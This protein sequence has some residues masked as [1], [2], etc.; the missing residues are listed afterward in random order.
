M[1]AS[2]SSA[3]QRNYF[4]QT[5]VKNG[6]SASQ[7][8]TW[9]VNAWGE[10]EI[11]LRRVQ[12]LCQE[13]RS[14]ERSTAERL[15]G[16]GRPRSSITEEN[17]NM[18]KELVEANNQLS[19]AALEM[20]SGIPA[21]TIQRILT[22]ELGKKSLCARWVP[23][24]LSQENRDA[25]LRQ[26][27]EILKALRTRRIS[28][29]LIIVDEKWIYHRH[30]PPRNQQR[31]WC[32][33]AGDRV[34]VARRT[35]SDAKTM[36][37]WSS[38]FEGHMFVQMVEHGRSVDADCYEGF[39]GR[40]TMKFGQ[41]SPPLPMENIDNAPAHRA[42]STGEWLQ[43]N[44]IATIKQPAYSPDFNLCDRYIFRNFETFRS[45]RDFEAPQDLLAAVREYIT[46]RSRE[47]F[48]EEMKRFEEDLRLIVDNGGDYL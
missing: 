16:S 23:H 42:R 45:G 28:R 12:C 36:Y 40:M 41:L 21:R 22:D 32:D 25:R 11:S 34:K 33:G 18:V 5:M 19:C 15:P 7:I 4:I 30:L 38:N 8:H 9:L 47:E 14:G 44:N 24:L 29:R 10:D 31:A 43:S 6:F 35:I 2:S 27:K 1:E 37:I 46:G 13:F 20:M 39:L 26:A 48:L 3:A 17:I